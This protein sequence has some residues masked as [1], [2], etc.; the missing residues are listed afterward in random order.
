LFANG[1]KLSVAATTAAYFVVLAY[2]ASYITHHVALA[3]C[4]G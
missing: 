3:I 4:L 2:I 1:G